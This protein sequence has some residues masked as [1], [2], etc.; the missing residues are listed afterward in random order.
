MLMILPLAFV[1]VKSGA[2]PQV[3]GVMAGINAA[4]IAIL[5]AATIRFARAAI[6]DGFTAII[7]LL[8]ATAGFVAWVKFPQFQP[9]LAI[10]ATAAV[11]GAIYYGKPRIS[12]TALTSILSLAPSP[13]WSQIGRMALFLLKVGATLFGSGYVLVSYLQS[14]LVDHY[15]WLTKR[16]LLDAIS[17]GQ[18]TPGPLLTT[19]TFVGYVLGN[20][21]FGGGVAGGITGGIIATIMIFLPAFL[22]IAILS[23]LLPHIRA[24]RFAHG[25][26]GDERGGRG[27]DPGCE[28]E[29][30][31]GRLGAASSSRRNLHRC[32]GGGIASASPI[33]RESDLA[34]S[35]R[36][37]DRTAADGLIIECKTP[38][39]T[40]GVKCCER[41]LYLL[42]LLV[43][44]CWQLCRRADW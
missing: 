5:I 17:I 7:G 15:H 22:I 31:I 4:V 39:H 2:L 43:S 27:A 33:R 12:T 36:S 24:D 20:R 10:L 26:D 32:G 40:P 35:G 11:L 13:Y 25:A 16:E 23:Q 21:Q 9:E 6:I 3:S 37:R 28:L 8:S 34:D 42:R 1:Y 41:S 30:G 29:A 38:G 14:G 18:M 44:S 19:S